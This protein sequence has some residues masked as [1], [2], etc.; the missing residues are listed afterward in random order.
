MPA[1]IYQAKKHIDLLIY[2]VDEKGTKHPIDFS[3]GTT[4][5][6]R[7]KGSYATDNPAIQ[8]AL[9]TSHLKDKLY[10]CLT[11]DTPGQQQKE[12]PLVEVPEVYNVQD[13]RSYLADNIEG[14]SKNALKSRAIVLEVAAEHG[15]SFPNLPT[16]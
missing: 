1:K 6:H 2:V 9:D 3:G 7:V 10:T 14:M 5:P 11:P 12:S 13:A 16:S 4:Y 8:K 15:Y